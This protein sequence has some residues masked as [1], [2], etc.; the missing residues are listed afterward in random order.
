LTFSTGI[1]PAPQG[2]VIRI[3]ATGTTTQTAGS[4]TSVALT[5]DDVLQSGRYSIVN[6]S[7][8]AAT[9]IAGRLLVDGTQYRCGSLGITT[10]G[11]AEHMS[12]SNR[13]YGEWAQFSYPNLPRCEFLSSSGDTAQ[14]VF[15]D[16]VRIS[17]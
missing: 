17:S 4:W 11:N 16:V 12:Y 5:F 1:K 6:A 3:H 15:I 13:W 10:F 8:V 7:F 14:D 2:Q 9:A